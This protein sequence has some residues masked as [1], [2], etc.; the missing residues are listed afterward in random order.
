MP[1]VDMNSLVIQDPV[2]VISYIKKHHLH[3]DRHIGWVMRLSISHDCKG[4]L[5]KVHSMMVKPYEKRFK[6]GVQVPR[7]TKEAY[8]LDLQNGNTLWQE[9]IAKEVNQLN[10]FKTFIILEVGE[11]APRDTQEYHTTLSMM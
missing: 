9:A 8:Y 10:S 4:Q 2:P 11:E 5:S 7:G 1:W 3:G 6:F